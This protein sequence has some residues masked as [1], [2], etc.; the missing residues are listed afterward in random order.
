MAIMNKAAL[1][2][3]G[4]TLLSVSGGAQTNS[5]SAPAQPVTSQ[6][7]PAFVGDREPM[8]NIPITSGDLL[9][10]EIFNTPE[11]SGKLRVDQ[12]GSVMLP[13]G[14][15][16]KVDGMLPNQA[17][18][19]IQN[20]LLTSKIMLNPTVTVDIVDYSTN[21]VTVLGEVKA[22][23]VYTLLGPRSLYDALAAAG[24][25]TA[26]AGSTITLTRA[27]DATHPIIVEVT[28][29]NYSPA[30]KA[31]VVL[32]GDTVVVNRAPLIYAVGDF[33]RSGAFYV[34]GG[35]KLTVLNVV[36]LAQGY[37]RT[38]AMGKASI[39]HPMPDGTAEIFRI[40]L[41]KILKGQESS[42]VLQAG[43][44]LVLPRSGVKDFALT[45]LPGAANSVVSAAA[46]SGIQ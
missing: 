46:Y 43:D 22:P 34:Q 18:A 11:L 31:T 1:V 17:A 30:I 3:V 37:N 26:S 5:P 9:D 25:V 42:P 24:G 10:V 16:V 29:P 14:G 23:G 39:I 2:L 13:M 4:F 40:N 33:V 44:V 21:G 20:R 38:A 6:V 32:P 15:S 45:A 8:Q 41:N 27:N 36:S 28:T 19:A 7:G 35:T 12:Q